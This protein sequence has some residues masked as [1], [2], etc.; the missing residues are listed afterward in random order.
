MM[1]PEVS[2]RRQQ[3]LFSRL[4]RIVSV[5]KDRSPNTDPRF[6]RRGWNLGKIVSAT[7]P[8]V[9]N[10]FVCGM[11]ALRSRPLAFEATQWL[12]SIGRPMKDTNIWRTDS[13]MFHVKQETDPIVE[14][15]KTPCMDSLRN[16]S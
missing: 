2:H 1:P 7:D 6:T 8:E 3:G 9:P 4:P 15:R 16:N 12:T 11:L 13:S 14:L 10:M 5:R